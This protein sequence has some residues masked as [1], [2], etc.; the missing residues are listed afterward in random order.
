MVC[1]LNCYT[2]VG[3]TDI[4][5]TSEPGQPEA[6]ASLEA[7]RQACMYSSECQGIT[8]KKGWTEGQ[9]ECLGKKAIHTAKCV[10]GG[11]YNTEILR[12]H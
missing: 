1:N 6:T 5:I 2:D 9:G 7:C 8:Y 11:E 10:P 12:E 4:E 3:A